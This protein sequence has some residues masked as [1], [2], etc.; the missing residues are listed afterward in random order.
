[1]PFPVE[2]TPW[3]EVLAFLQEYAT[4]ES[5]ILA[6]NEFLEFFPGNYPY[7]VTRVLP[8][9]HFDVV[10]WHKAMLPELDLSFATEVLRRFWLIYD[11]DVFSVFM[12]RPPVDLPVQDKAKVDDFKHYFN[13]VMGTQPEVKPQSQW[14]IVV[15]VRDRPDALVRSLPQI[16]A[17]N[18]P[19][20]VIDDGSRPDHA[21]AYR[22]ITNHPSVH[23][24][25]FPQRRGMPAALNAGISYWLADPSIEWISCFREDVD[26][27]PNTR[28]I[29]SQIQDAHTRP[30]LTGRDALEH[31]DFGV[32]AIAGYQTRRK[33]SMPGVHLHGHRDYWAGVLPIPTPIRSEAEIAAGRGMEEDWWITAWSPQSIVK[34]GHYLICVPGLV[35][36][37][38]D[39]KTDPWGGVVLRGGEELLEEEVKSQPLVIPQFS[40][41]QEVVP[42]IEATETRSPVAQPTA[43]SANFT[44]VRSPLHLDIPDSSLTLAGT[45]VL[46]DGYN[47][48][49]TS[50]TGIKTYS[51]SLI[52]GLT[53]LGAQVDVLLSRNASKVNEVLDE[54][55]FYDNQERSPNLLLDSIDMGKG[56]IKSS[57]GPFFKA[58]RRKSVGRFVVKEGKYGDDFLKYAESFNSP[59]CYTVANLLFKALRYT[60]NL[61]IA[62]Q[63]DLWHA[64][65]PLPITIRGAKKI[66]TIHDLIPLRLP[67]ATLD[68]KE[69]FYFRVR[70]ALK[71]SAV[72][73]S[74]SEHSKKDLLEYFDAD[75]D[76]IV[77]T[78]QP[79]ALEYEEIADWQAA[80]Y[81]QRYGLDYQKYILFVGAIEPKKNIGRLLDAYAT[82]DTDLPLVVVGKKGW[83]WQDEL[84][85]IS[86]VGAKGSNKQVKMLEYVPINSLKYLYRGAYCLVFPS[87]YEGFGLPP[88]EAMT[89]GCPVIT[90]QV[91]SLPE[92]CGNAALYVDPYDVGNLRHQME[93]ILGDRAL[94]DQL[95]AMG[96]ENAQ[97][98][99]QENYVKRLFYAYSKALQA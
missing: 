2:D 41:V 78:Y 16:L 11:N 24:I 92:V 62:E 69:E 13:E 89:F 72:I 39:P 15:T 87:L 82:L 25:Q 6:P 23:L 67:Y 76:R 33:R 98:F 29:L 84:N 70:D 28:N 43:L 44:A 75:P 58:K 20:V 42:T 4:A 7:E 99:S 27:H 95:S 40:K 55:L 77:V 85:K 91:S 17:L 71:D 56:L 80:E 93:V 61:H 32:A 74:V 49:L 54:V 48:Q 8:S 59:R 60:T 35:R 37:F 68:N 34:Q 3:V 90:S 86:F 46:V 57:L 94:R 53:R 88:L 79:I 50:G 9:D 36:C 65:Y 1:M 22:Q 26:V 12:K 30:L 52:Q 38:D 64:T 5:K 63:I 83:L 47:L 97:F 21:A 45:K 19:V 18:A 81:L 10:I 73:I 14:G 66:T 51:N 31:P 96:R